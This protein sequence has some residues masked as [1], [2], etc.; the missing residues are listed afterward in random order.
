M[1]GLLGL[2]FLLLALN[3]LA[4]VVRAALLLLLLVSALRVALCLI[5]CRLASVLGLVV[6]LSYSHFTAHHHDAVRL[7]YLVL[8]RGI[9]CPELR[10]F[11]HEHDKDVTPCSA[12]LAAR[13][14]QQRRAGKWL[15]FGDRFDDPMVKVE[16]G[17][18]PEG[19]EPVRLVSIT[20]TVQTMA[21][22]FASERNTTLAKV[23]ILLIV[24]VMALA[25]IIDGVRSMSPAHDSGAHRA[26]FHRGPAR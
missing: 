18:V 12:T 6:H 25:A 1:A 17:G 5:Q 16:W 9:A 22:A 14:G 13:E 21:R 4:G 24:G 2:R 8:D 26:G 7:S 11:G 19:A 20:A 23:V 3:M 15:V 10:S